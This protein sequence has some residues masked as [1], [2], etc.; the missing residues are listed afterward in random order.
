M[1]DHVGRQL[2]DPLASDVAA[3]ARFPTTQTMI[4]GQGSDAPSPTMHEL[5]SWMGYFQLADSPRVQDLGEWFRRRMRQIRW[6]GWKRPKT[7]QAMPRKFGI[8]ELVLP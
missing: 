3:R 4:N 1:T 5:V 6:K 8:N 7:R 2:R